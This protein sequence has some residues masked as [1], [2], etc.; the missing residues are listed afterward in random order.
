MIEFKHHIEFKQQSN[1]NVDAPEGGGNR[2]H[3][4]RGVVQDQQGRHAG[5]KDARPFVLDAM[6]TYRRAYID[7]SM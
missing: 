7:A 1:S 4:G 5:R 6:H 2:L 3:R